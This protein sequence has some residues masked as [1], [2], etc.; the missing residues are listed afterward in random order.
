MCGQA[1]GQ[2]PCNVC[3]YAPDAVSHG[4]DRTAIAYEEMSRLTSEGRLDSQT[5]A[6]LRDAIYPQGV[7]QT[8]AEQVI[9]TLKQKRGMQSAGNTGP[10]PAV[11]VQPVPLPPPMAQP[12][13]AVAP[14]DMVPLASLA[15]SAEVA[16]QSRPTHVTEIARV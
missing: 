6:K 10:R 3:G 16:G 5:F 7:P 11:H 2:Y 14:W 8:G 12:S 4:A 1:I 13:P 9:R 15:A